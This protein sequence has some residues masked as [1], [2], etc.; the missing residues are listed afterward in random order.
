MGSGLI[1]VLPGCSSGDD[2]IDDP[3]DTESGGAGDTTPGD[4]G[5]STPTQPSG[6]PDV[7]FGDRQ[8]VVDD[9]GFTTEVYAEVVVENTGD[10]AAGRITLNVDW[11]D[12]AD[13]YLEDTSGS[14]PSLDA[15]EVW[16]AQV[17]ALPADVEDIERFELSGEF[18]SN[19]PVAPEGMQVTESE[20]EIE[21]YFAQITGVAENDRD[22]EIRYVEAHGRIYDGQGRVIGGGWTNETEIP[23]GRNWAFE[24]HI[25]GRSK[26]RAEGAADHVAFLDVD[27]F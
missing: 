3:Q 8:L 12:A 20:I 13:N 10:A 6:E 14:L 23:A 2:E 24:I 4:P 16:I 21:E 17:S 22:D 25:T 18:E 15:G 19:S 26:E 9:S 5:E 7:R 11:Y 27:P 1:A